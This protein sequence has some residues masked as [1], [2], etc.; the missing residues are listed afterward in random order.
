MSRQFK[1]NTRFCRKRFSNF[2]F[3]TAYAEDWSQITTF[4]YLKKGFK[5]K[6]TDYYFKP[7]MD[8][9][10][11]LETQYQDTMP[12]CAGPESQGRE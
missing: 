12:F 2:G 10:V 9:L 7:Y 4:N 5:E 8:A 3:A 6:P 11:L 1:I